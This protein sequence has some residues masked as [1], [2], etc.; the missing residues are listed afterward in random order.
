M[1]DVGK[2]LEVNLQGVSRRA[3]DN[4]LRVMFL[5]KTLHFVVIN[6]LGFVQA[7]GNAVEV[8]SGEV[9]LH[10]VAQV[11]AVRKAHAH[12]GVARLQK[13]HED[14]HVRLRA[15]MRLHVH[16]HL[17]ARRLAKELLRALDRDLL[18]LVHVLAAAVVALAGIAFGIFVGELAALRRHDGRRCV[19]LARN[20]LDVRLLALHLLSNESPDF[21]VGDG[22]RFLRVK[23]AAIPSFFGWV[24]RGADRVAPPPIEGL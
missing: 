12:E 4:E 11:A 23:H 1:R 24:E 21:A 22:G 17:N 15:R 2:A 16:G 3:R 14:R 9:D 20:H 5:C 19:V 7:I 6:R 18:H 10:A 8:L 13:R